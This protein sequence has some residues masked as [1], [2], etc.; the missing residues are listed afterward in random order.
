MI[1][2]ISGRLVTNVPPL[3][4]VDAHGVGYEIEVPM[5]TF[6]ALPERGEPVT[7]IT[8]LSI[9]EDGHYLYGFATAEERIAFRE[10]LKVTGIGPRTALGVLSGMSV[11][12]LGKAIA[13]QDVECL[14]RIPGIGRKTAERVVLDLKTKFPK[15]L[16]SLQQPTDLFQAEA[17]ADITRAL[18]NLGYS[19]K[20]AAGA[21][22]PLPA[23]I[24][25]AAGI[26]QALQA[27]VAH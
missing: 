27:L 2:Q 1:G 24:A 6:C 15:A 22:K 9:K 18:I 21:V 8:H 13:N 20:E 11:P 25:L 23:N 26:R 19:E 3:I 17:R 4:T 16:P 5:S 14:V 7:L 10:L 12:L